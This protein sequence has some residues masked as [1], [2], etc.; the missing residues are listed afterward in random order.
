MTKQQA[1]SPRALDRSRRKAAA[2]AEH[3]SP[4]AGWIV[5]TTTAAKIVSLFPCLSVRRGV[6]LV[7]VAAPRG[8]LGGDGGTFATPKG[9][10][11]PSPEALE[12]AAVFPHGPPRGAFVHVMDAID[13]DGSLRSYAQA[14]ILRRELEELGAGWHGIE[15][16]MHTL[17]DNGVAPKAPDAC[18]ECDDDWGQLI[19]DPEWRWE[20]PAPDDWRPTIERAGPDNVAVMFFTTSARGRFHIT[21]H[22]DFYKSGSLRSQSTEHTIAEGPP[23]IEC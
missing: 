15:W 13:G 10:E 12:R 23:G 5:D 16:G 11:V 17:L 2:L 18:L 7:T 8:G 6:R 4:E 3:L 14:S 21:R 1:V 9:F 19:A 22:V 20:A